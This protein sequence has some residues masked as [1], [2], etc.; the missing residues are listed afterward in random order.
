MDKKNPH[1]FNREKWIEI[2]KSL[3]SNRKLED[4]L[5]EEFI[6]MRALLKVI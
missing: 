5:G 6:E 1:Q 4:I 2:F 3:A